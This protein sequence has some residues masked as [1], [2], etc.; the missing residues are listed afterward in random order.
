MELSDKVLHEYNRKDKDCF[1]WLAM[2][3]FELQHQ[4]PVRIQELQDLRTAFL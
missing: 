2:L 3:V 1:L 4:C